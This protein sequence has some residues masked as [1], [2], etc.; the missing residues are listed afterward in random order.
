MALFLAFETRFRRPAASIDGQ[1]MYT[2]EFGT[3]RVLSDAEAQEHLAE[4]EGQP[5][6]LSNIPRKTYRQLINPWS[7][8]TPNGGRVVVR[9][10]IHMAEAFTSPGL[11]YALLVATIVLGCAIG[12]S[13]TY[14]TVL[15]DNYGWSAASIGLIN[16]RASFNSFQHLLILL[17]QLGPV[18]ASIAAMLYAGYVGDK[19][20]LWMAR[21]NNGVH[22]PEHRLPLLIVPGIVGFGGILLYGLTASNPGHKFSWWAPV[23]GWTLLEFTFVCALILSTTFAAEAWPKN[24][25]PALVVVVGAKNIIS[26]GVTYGLTPMI[27]KHGYEWSCSVL[28]G[29]MAGIMLLGIP[30]YFFNPKWRKFVAERDA[31][32]LQASGDATL[33]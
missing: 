26:F 9:A 31:K 1:L 24:P 12:I 5:E 25:G 29:I 33:A 10:Y 2:D 28:A 4:L 7:G 16:V 20:T 13:L 23:M 6:D 3:T 8:T 17:V 32:K 15:Q 11:V 30:V 18:P 14:D 19:Y 27:A 21:R 22:T